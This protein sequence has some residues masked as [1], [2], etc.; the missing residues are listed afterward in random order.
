MQ[1]LFTVNNHVALLSITIAPSAWVASLVLALVFLFLYLPPFP[2]ILPKSL[3]RFFTQRRRRRNTA[4]PQLGTRSSSPI[5][6]E[7]KD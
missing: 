7:E 5:Y 1:S 2:S 3:F 6:E 4:A